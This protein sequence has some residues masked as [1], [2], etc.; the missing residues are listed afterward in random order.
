MNEENAQTENNNPI[1]N[2]VQATQSATQEVP[3]VSAV[4]MSP[5][6][7]YPAGVQPCASP[8]PVNKKLPWIIA[9]AIVAAIMMGL[10]GVGTYF[11][12]DNNQRQS[13][14]VAVF[15]SFGEEKD[16]LMRQWDAIDQ[17]DWDQVFDLISPHAELIERME[18]QEDYM[19]ASARLSDREV[20]DLIDGAQ[21][22]KR[23]VET[24][25]RH[26][27]ELEMQEFEARMQQ[28]LQEFEDAMNEVLEWSLDILS[29]LD[30]DDWEALREEL[31]GVDLDDLDLS[32]ITW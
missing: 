21:N 26:I 10:I 29:D 30:E 5:V 28:E 20:S 8:S 32:D 11:I 7:N 2:S 22:N 27:E 3:N 12:V 24:Q 15:T 18:D 4:P 25:L 17:D 31:L 14:K 9:A 13:A 6:N 19:R 16:R 23:M 1:D